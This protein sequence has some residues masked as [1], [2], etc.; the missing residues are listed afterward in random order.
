MRAGK[1]AEITGDLTERV[2]VARL[3]ERRADDTESNLEFLLGAY[4]RCGREMNAAT[5]SA[6]AAVPPLRIFPDSNSKKFRFILS[7]VHA[8]LHP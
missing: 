3:T 6:E 8:F 2:L 7:V 4:S 1:G 5:A